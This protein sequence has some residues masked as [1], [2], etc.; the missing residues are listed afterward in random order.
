VKLGEL[1]AVFAEALVR[2]ASIARE[3][4]WPVRGDALFTGS[5]RLSPIEQLD[6]YR[7]QFWLRHV[8]CLA[9]D[10]PTLQ[11]FVG[12]ARFEALVADYLTA[13][14]PIHFQL[15]HLGDHLADF[16]GR[17]GEALLSDI[18]RVEWAYIDAFDAADAP[19]LDPRTVE[20]IAPDAWPLVHIVFHPSL[21]RVRLEH[22]A[23][24]MRQAVRDNEPLT[25]APRHP[26]T[27]AIY[28]R[29]LLLYTEDVDALPFELLDRLARG[30]ALGAAGDAL[31]RSTGREGEIEANIGGWFARWSALGWI[32]SVAQ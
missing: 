1:Q 23:Q 28:R 26:T 27:L 9:D 24:L 30:E 17:K 21:Q 8:T 20:A 25:A 4:E 5:A 19:P 16:L 18:A 7:E 12:A 31:A 32:V 29:D 6:V 2:P 13:H 15:R 11:S 3:G 14:P 10:F 22:P